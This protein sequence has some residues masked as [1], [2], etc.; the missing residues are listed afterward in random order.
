MLANIFPSFFPSMVLANMFVATANQDQHVREHV[1]Q[2]CSPTMFD[3]LRPPYVALQSFVSIE[4]VG[5]G[6]LRLSQSLY[7]TVCVKFTKSSYF[8]RRHKIGPE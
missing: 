6:F 3:G 5:L 8:L 1:R 2:Q 4:K 7:I